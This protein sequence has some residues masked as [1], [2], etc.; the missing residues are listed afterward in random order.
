MLD[1][2]FFVG[3]AGVESGEDL[4]CIVVVVEGIFHFV[5]IVVIF[6]VGENWWCINS[7]AVLA[8]QFFD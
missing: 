2:D 5:A 6:A 3:T 8:E 4:L 1:F 7:D